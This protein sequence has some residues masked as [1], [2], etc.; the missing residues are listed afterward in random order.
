[1]EAGQD[2]RLGIPMEKLHLF[3]RESENTLDT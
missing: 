3:D 2:V 1:V